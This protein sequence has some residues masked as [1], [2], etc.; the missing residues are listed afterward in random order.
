RFSGMRFLL[1]RYLDSANFVVVM[2]SLESDLQIKALQAFGAIEKLVN[3]RPEIPFLV[4]ILWAH[5]LEVR[6]RPTAAHRQKRA[7]L[8][9]ANAEGERI[10]GHFRLE[11]TCARAVLRI[12]CSHA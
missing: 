5:G 6:R 7:E 8:R 9:R 1:Q 12:A 10:V 3:R 11:T 2:K 4:P